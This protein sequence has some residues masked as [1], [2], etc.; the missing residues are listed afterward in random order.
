MISV[1]ECQSRILSQIGQATPPE[2]IP[3]KK[4]LGR[5]LAVEIQ[6]P[7]GVPPRD[8]SAVDGYAVS[9]RDLPRDGVVELRVVGELPAGSVFE[10]VVQRGEAVRIMTGAPLPKGV[11]SVVPQE[12]VE[13]SGDHVLIR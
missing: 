5:C 13:R 4:S 9:S 8:S 7:F 12:D 10:R 6:G 1:Q 2:V 3:V 11:D